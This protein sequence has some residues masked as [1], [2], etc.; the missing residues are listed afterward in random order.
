MMF[1]SVFLNLKL[2]TGKPAMINFEVALMFRA[3]IW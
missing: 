3:A 1:F 2:S